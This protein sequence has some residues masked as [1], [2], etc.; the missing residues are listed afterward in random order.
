MILKTDQL[1]PAYQAFASRSA[2]F[3]ENAACQKGCAFCCS[4]AGSI[5]ITTLE[6]LAIR[7]AVNHLPAP[8]R[9]SVQ[10]NLARDM[11]RRE[12]GQSSRCPFLMKNNACMIY[13]HRPF[14]CRRI[15]SLETCGK[16]RPPLLSRQ[17]MEMADQ[18]I[19]ELQRLDDTGYSGHL[20][21]I[22]HMLDTPVFLESYLAGEFRPEAIM[23][24]GKTHKILINRMA[25][26]PPSI[27]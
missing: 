16:T 25:A 19:C 22:L 2:P 7:D 12:N 5:H 24:F 21:Y 18:T 17:V 3:R 9:K 13:V 10:K 27:K 23:D 1:G 15:Y 6:G 11:K 14:I 20:S 26:K 8:Q 4:D